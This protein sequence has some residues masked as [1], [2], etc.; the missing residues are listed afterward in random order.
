[1][2]PFLLIENSQI[3]KS[4]RRFQNAEIRRTQLFEIS[5]NKESFQF[6]H[7]KMKMAVQHNEMM[8]PEIENAIRR[9]DSASDP[10]CDQ[11]RER[12]RPPK[13]DRGG[14]GGRSER[15]THATNGRGRGDHER[16]DREERGAAGQTD[17]ADKAD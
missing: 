2:N 11:N 6:E 3:A 14:R 5:I 12:G 8:D 16:G 9:T 7:V 15:A 10:D 1:M 13:R 17:E 4:K